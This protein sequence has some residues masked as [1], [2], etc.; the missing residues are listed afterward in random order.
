MKL[1]ELSWNISLNFSLTL[2]IISV[3]KLLNCNTHTYNVTWL[4]V[5]LVSYVL[6][7]PKNKSLTKSTEIHKLSK[8]LESICIW[9]EALPILYAELY[10]NNV[11]K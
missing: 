11:E 1:V 6:N 9:Y 5:D 2:T 3:I 10:A 4:F 8:C 7:K